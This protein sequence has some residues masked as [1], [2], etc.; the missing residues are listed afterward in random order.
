M[1]QEYGSTPRRRRTTRS[2]RNR[3][4]LVTANDSEQ[5]A[6][7]QSVE[8]TATAVEEP[9]YEDTPQPVPPTRTRRLPKFF[10]TVGKEEKESASETKEKETV[11]QARLARATRSKSSAAGSKTTT[12]ENVPATKP[13]EKSA[14]PASSAAA[15]RTAPARPASPFKT[16]YIFGML[17]YIV[18]STFLSSVELN[19]MQSQKLD[20]PLTV[21]NLFGLQ[22]P[23]STFT[24][25][26]LATLV[27]LLIL[28]AYFDFLPR[29]FTSASN[30][31]A[32][33]RQAQRSTSQK[34]TTESVGEGPRNIPP[35]VRQGVKGADDDLYQEYR[36]NQRREKKR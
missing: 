18:G 35:P 3:P 7:P 13:V 19:F 24:L 33:Q 4:I 25:V 2:Q 9:V 17:I 20:K 34:G 14:K 10:S 27:L 26:Y 6:V 8:E 23:I 29:G 11:A 21:L 15:S 28:L 36:L 31:R 30:A 32:T 12:T 5:Q 16:R 1:S 22:L